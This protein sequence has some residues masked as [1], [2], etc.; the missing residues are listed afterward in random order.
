MLPVTGFL[1][2]LGRSDFYAG[3]DGDEFDEFSFQAFEGDTVNITMSFD[4]TNVNFDMELWDAN[5]NWLGS[6]YNDNDNEYIT[7]TIQAGDTAPFYIYCWWFIGA[8]DYTIDA[9][10]S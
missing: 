5:G 6:S 10:I 3:F 8:G 2:S 7:Y 1:A 9:S 4:Y